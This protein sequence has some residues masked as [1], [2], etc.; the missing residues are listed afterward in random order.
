MVSTTAPRAV[1]GEPVP[2]NAPRFARHHHQAF[3]MVGAVH[4][5]KSGAPRLS[6]SLSHRSLRSLAGNARKWPY[7]VC[8]A[9]SSYQSLASRPDGRLSSHGLL[10]VTHQPSAVS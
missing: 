6:I 9:D 3:R 7:H 5:L 4:H 1:D 2:R 8:R 10:A